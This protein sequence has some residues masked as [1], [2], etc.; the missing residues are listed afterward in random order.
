MC[1]GSAAWLSAFCSPWLY[2]WTQNDTNLKDKL[3]PAVYQCS[4]GGNISIYVESMQGEVTIPCQHFVAGIHFSRHLSRKLYTVCV[5]LC[6]R[7]SDLLVAISAQNCATLLAVKAKQV[8]GVSL[9]STRHNGART[10]PFMTFEWWIMTLFT[11]KGCVVFMT[12]RVWDNLHK[13]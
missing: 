13:L 7:L 10:P 12:L 4:R 6:L 3:S 1:I 8:N 9:F 11:T 2:L 5:C